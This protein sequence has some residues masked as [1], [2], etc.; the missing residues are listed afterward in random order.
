LPIISETPSNQLDFIKQ[1]LECLGGDK[2]SFLGEL[3]SESEP[4]PGWAGNSVFLNMQQTHRVQTSLPEAIDYVMEGSKPQLDELKASLQDKLSK[5]EPNLGNVADLAARLYRLA[6]RL[7]D[8]EY[9][10]E[11]FAYALYCAYYIPGDGEP[12][13]VFADA[14]G[15][16]LRESLAVRQKLA[17]LWPTL[18]GQTLE[19]ALRLGRTD[20][21]LKFVWVRFLEK[22]NAEIVRWVILGLLADQYKAPDTIWLD[23]ANKI[24]TC[25]DNL[26]DIG[27]TPEKVP[28]WQ[29]D[30]VKL[31]GVIGAQWLRDKKAEDLS[32]L[33]KVAVRLPKAESAAKT[34]YLVCQDLKQCTDKPDKPRAWGS[35]LCYVLDACRQVLLVSLSGRGM[36]YYEA[37]VREVIDGIE[38]GAFKKASYAFESPEYYLI[39]ELRQL[40]VRT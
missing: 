6:N 31:L 25:I 21:A 39:M 7:E 40:S 36:S 2:Q 3:V 16:D 18:D 33:F 28:L 14:Y 12:L 23:M 37:V 32:R 34:D 13:C 29:Y 8:I 11:F 17:K 35:C 22:D 9:R 4:L 38:D 10:A 26:V 15:G 24:F 5:Q 1:F 19:N 27:N 20:P 30:A